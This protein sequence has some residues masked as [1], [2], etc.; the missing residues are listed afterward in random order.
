MSLRRDAIPDDARIRACSP[1]RPVAVEHAQ[2]IGT[3]ESSWTWHD[4]GGRRAD[5]GRKREPG[6]GHIPDRSFSGPKDKSNLNPQPGCLPEDRQH[7]WGYATHH[8]RRG[9]LPKIGLELHRPLKIEL[10]GIRPI[11]EARIVDRFREGAG[12][13][14]AACSLAGG[15]PRAVVALRSSSPPQRPAASLTAA[16][17]AQPH[18]PAELH[19]EGAPGRCRYSGT[20]WILQ[21]PGISKAGHAR[22]INRPSGVAVEGVAGPG[23]S[24]HC[25]ER[26]SPARVNGK[27]LRAARGQPRNTGP[28]ALPAVPGRDPFRGN[29]TRGGHRPMPG[30][31]GSG[32]SQGPDFDGRQCRSPRLNRRVVHRCRGVR[33]HVGASEQARRD[34]GGPGRGPGA[35]FRCRKGRRLAG[36]ASLR[37]CRD[38]EGRCERDLAGWHGAGPPVHGGRI[39]ALGTPC[40]ASP[41]AAGPA[42]SR[43][44]CSRSP[45]SDDERPRRPPPRGAMA[46]RGSRAGFPGATSRETQPSRARARHGVESRASSNRSRKRQGPQGCSRTPPPRR[47]PAP[48]PARNR[49]ALRPRCSAPCACCTRKA[50]RRSSLPGWP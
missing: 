23:K 33:G 24:G 9:L 40:G 3:R 25:E 15:V 4:V 22:V 35:A 2:K 21:E 27:N 14:V 47:P 5:H 32:I 38:A 19:P 17:M 1:N 6:D 37:G 26:M 43:G 44:R 34:G 42:L 13:A 41:V 28:G 20:A 31:M 36:A 49:G 10:D 48:R 8:R 30:G 18:M 39:A 29:D 12:N 16:D 45:R 46:R 11:T 7:A 50:P